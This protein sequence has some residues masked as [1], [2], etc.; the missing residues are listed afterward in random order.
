MAL[1]S[2]EANHLLQKRSRQE[3][4]V[5]DVLICAL[6]AT[7]AFAITYL[8]LGFELRYSSLVVAVLLGPGTFVVFCLAVSLVIYLRRRRR[9]SIRIWVGILIGMIAGVLAGAAC[10][11]AEYWSYAVKYY[12]YK[13]MAS[14]TNVDV[15]MDIGQSYMD[16]GLVYF[17]EGTYV[18][19]VKALAFHNGATYCVAPIVRQPLQISATAAGASSFQ[20][21]TETGFVPPASGTVDFWAVGKDCCGESGNTFECGAASSSVARSG[22]RLLNDR[23]RAMYLLAVQEWAASAGLP[24]RHPLFFEWVKDPLEDLD[25]YKSSA[26]DEFWMNLL[27]FFLFSLIGAFLIFFALQMFKVY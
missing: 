8:C 15:G 16:A 5:A 14:Y 18:R 7:F 9:Q 21:M 26:W 25:G 19:K 22:M 17:K 4:R 10:A 1:L 12:T 27:I 3:Q 23:E 24:V 20:M 6:L 13:D 2:A 11:N